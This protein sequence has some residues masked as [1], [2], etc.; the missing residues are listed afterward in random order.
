MSAGRVN[1]QH[2]H[3]NSFKMCWPVSVV[4]THCPQLAGKACTLMHKGNLKMNNKHEFAL[5]RTSGHDESFNLIPITWKRRTHTEPVSYDSTLWKIKKNRLGVPSFEISQ[6]L[7]CY[8]S[9]H[10][11]TAYFLSRCSYNVCTVAA[12]AVWEQSPLVKFVEHKVEICRVWVLLLIKRKWYLWINRACFG[13]FPFEYLPRE[14]DHSSVQSWSTKSLD[15]TMRSVIN[16]KC[17]MMLNY[18]ATICSSV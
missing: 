10:T 2:S 11:H 4:L 13:S 7:S 14:T 12:L 16:K 17:F 5:E 18:L 1:R 9:T 3:H 8:K 6:S 15:C